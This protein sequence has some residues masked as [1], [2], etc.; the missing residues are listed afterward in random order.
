[1]KARQFR[2]NAATP[3]GHNA[4]AIGYPANDA[5]DMNRTRRSFNS[6]RS[7]ETNV[8]N[9]RSKASVERSSAAE[10]DESKDQVYALDDARTIM[11][12]GTH[13]SEIFRQS[14]KRSHARTLKKRERN[15]RLT[16]AKAQE[17]R[18]VHEPQ[19]SNSNY[20]NESSSGLNSTAQADNSSI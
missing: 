2:S 11:Y 4:P 6:V 8:T 13:F 7:H 18:V 10:V 9:K 3:T 16:E 1:M 5:T 14:L 12:K 17:R 19:I 20:I 15:R